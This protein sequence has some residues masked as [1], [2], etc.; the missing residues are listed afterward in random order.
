MRNRTLLPSILSLT[1]VACAALMPVSGQAAVGP[2]TDLASNPVQ[3]TVAAVFT[4]NGNVRFGPDQK[5]KP[6]V[7]LKAESPVEVIGAAL[8]A[9]DWLVIRFPKEGKAWVREDKITPI[10]DG[11]RWRVIRDRSNARDDAT[12]GANI[13]AQ[14]AVGEVLEDKGQKVGNWV[15][16]YIPNAIAYTHKDNVRLASAPPATGQTATTTTPG[17]VVAAVKTVS[18]ENRKQAE[19]SERVWAAAVSTY[20]DFRDSVTARLEVALNKDW[21]GLERQLAEVIEKHPSQ[22]TRLAA[23]QIKVAIDKVKT[24]A[25]AYAL[26]KNIE[27]KVTDPVKEPG[28]VPTTTHTGVGPVSSGTVPGANPGVTALPGKVAVSP[29]AADGLLVQKDLTALDIHYAIMDGDGNVKAYLKAKDPAA[30]QL[31]EYYYRNVGVK[32]VKD[33]IDAAKAGIENPPPLV[34]VEEVVLLGR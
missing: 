2:D 11:K 5:A 7:M 10:D 25:K 17:D 8:G 19:E 32:G 24:E 28:K 21:D 1:L 16:V 13:V 26:A 4:R 31:S 18:E 14:L 33:P 22:A 6:V 3:K 29:Y 23:A 20:G 27:I 34:T 12:L 9:P 30:L 15:A